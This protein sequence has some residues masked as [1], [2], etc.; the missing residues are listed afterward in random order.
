MKQIRFVLKSPEDT[1]EWL[2]EAAERLSDDDMNYIASMAWM[3]GNMEDF[4]FNDDQ[5]TSDFMDH[6]QVLNEEET[7]YIH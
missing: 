4:I 2:I 3:I 6:M 5:I 7:D 1:Q